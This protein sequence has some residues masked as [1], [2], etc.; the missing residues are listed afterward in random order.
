M[1]KNLKIIFL[2]FLVTRKNHQNNKIFIILLLSVDF[3]WLIIF[4]A[5]FVTENK[6][7]YLS[8]L[9]LAAENKGC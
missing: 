8:R 6:I 4:V 7:F 3:Y 2:L 9:F 1:A 5:L